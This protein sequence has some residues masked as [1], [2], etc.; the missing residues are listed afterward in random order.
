MKKIYEDFFNKLDENELDF[1]KLLKEEYLKRKIRDNEYNQN[2]RYISTDLPK[3]SLRYDSWNIECL[4]LDLDLFMDYLLAQ[5]F[6]H[7][8][9]KREREYCFQVT[10]LGIG[11]LKYIDENKKAE[12]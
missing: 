6:I 8:Y 10:S 9:F 1:F 4:N 3:Y 7:N 5:K 12:L 11:F 2:K